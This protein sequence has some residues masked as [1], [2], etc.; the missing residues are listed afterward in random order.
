M[1]REERRNRSGGRAIHDWLGGR[2]EMK[3]NF[4]YIDF[5]RK[6]YKDFSPQSFSL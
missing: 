3:E 1:R 4:Q 5:K 6:A 2:R